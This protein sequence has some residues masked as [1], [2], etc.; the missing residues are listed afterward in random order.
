VKF[1]VD[2]G[3]GPVSLEDH[4]W[5]L[6]KPCGCAVAITLSVVS[7]EEVL[8]TAEMAFAALEP[9][10]RMRERLTRYGYTVRLLPRKQASALFL[11]KCTHELIYRAVITHKRENG[12]SW[13]N[14]YGPYRTLNT[15]RGVATQKTRSRWRWGNEPDPTTTVAIQ[16]GIV[17]WGDM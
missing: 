8:A 11:A 2:L 13:T 14:T 12:P 3:D 5:A 17:T 9:H 10:K 15:A 1:T 7:E 4:D 16:Q 6:L